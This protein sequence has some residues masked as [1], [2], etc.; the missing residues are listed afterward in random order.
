[1]QQRGAMRPWRPSRSAT[2]FDFVPRQYVAR[3]LRLSRHHSPFM[4]RVDLSTFAGLLARDHGLRAGAHSAAEYGDLVT[5]IV[6]L[7]VPLDLEQA[8]SVYVGA[9]GTIV[10]QPF[11]SPPYTRSSSFPVTPYKRVLKRPNRHETPRTRAPRI[12]HGISLLIIR[13]LESVG[14]CRRT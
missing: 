10:S 13:R 3:A 7:D 4:E 12:N 8:V 1:M 9:T 6:K 14:T 2:F 11:A 5:L